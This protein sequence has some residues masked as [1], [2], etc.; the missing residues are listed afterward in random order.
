[1]T[2]VLPH[3]F[4][5]SHRAESLTHV[6]HVPP[7]AGSTAAWPSWAPP[8]LRTAFEARG[9]AL[10]WTHQAAAADL[11]WSGTHTVVATGT[12]SGKSLAYQL[13]ALSALLRDAKATMLYI[14][15]TKALAADQ[16]RSLQALDL[17]DTRPATF[18]GDT[19]REERDW[20]R[21]HARVV[22]TNPDMLHH[23]ILPNH[24]SWTRFLRGLRFVV[25]DECH[26][27]R[28][29]FGSHVAH[30]L[31]RL[32]RVTA[33]YTP[34]G[35]PSPCFVLA[36]A[37]SGDPQSSGSR[38]T[39][40]PMTAVTTDASPRG[41]VTFALWEPPLLPPPPDFSG[42]GEAELLLPDDPTLM[43]TVAER[44]TP[45]VATRPSATPHTSIPAPTT[46]GDSTTARGSTTAA[47]PTTTAGSTPAASP[48]T[49]AQS[50]TTALSLSTTADAK[51]AGDSANA[52]S[53]TTACASAPTRG[54]TTAA[55]P[56]AAHSS[57]TAGASAT[58]RRSTPTGGVATAAGGV[59]GAARDFA[60]AGRDAEPV[61]RSALRETADLLTEAV[62]AG[63]RTLAFVRSRKGA[64]VV[65]SMARRSLDQAVPGL[66]D[67]V[68]A[69]R[70]GYLREERRALE[71][72]L[73]D[74][75][76]LGLASTNAL[77]LGVDL[78][79][80]DAVLIS[81]YPGTL[82]SL[83]QQAG[84]AGRAGRDAL[85]VLVARDDPLDTYLVHHP[86]ALFGKPVEATVL[87]P[88][89]P[90]VLAPQLCC[91]AAELPLT[92]ADLPLFGPTAEATLDAL[93]ASGILRKRPSGWYWTERHRPDVDLRGAGGGP[94]AVVEEA[95]G[96]LL[97]T[98]DTGSA[99]HQVHTG[100]VHLHQGVSY[101]V[102]K[103]DLA[104]SVALVH[105]E[106]PDWSTH[107]RDVTSL[108]VLSV[109]Q[110]RT[111]GPVTLSLGEVEVTSQVVSYQRRRI[112]SGEVIDTCQLD[113]PE[114][115]LKTV[116]VWWTVSPEALDEAG[117]AEVDWPGA[118][119][120][121]EHASIGLLPL[122]ATCDRWDIGGLSTALHADT[123]LPTVFVY[124]GHPG[125]AGFAERAF[126]VATDW[127]GATRAVVAECRCEQGCPSCVQ[128]PKCGNGNNPLNKHDAVQVLSLVL[129]SL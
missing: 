17:P 8:S 2:A 115:I 42:I 49:S 128:S 31:R 44:T 11:A 62:I 21:Q 4:L 3:S 107:P 124:D 77:E 112:T 117:I 89:N 26:T 35:L 1:M 55:N 7:R 111:A 32:R 45:A 78:V 48:T 18:D 79:G 46:A 104:D 90:H 126:D 56:T 27:Y 122:V 93:V 71:R 64:E 108:T 73:M 84:R 43:T 85:C 25:V 127:L 114:R 100:A 86:E 61:R 103:L 92:P 59:A 94:I 9:V 40:L 39:G 60:G 82:A 19:S 15:P 123:G 38:L 101:V 37:T 99:H 75:T 47:T 63:V 50:P 70:A 109:R 80:L 95:T 125:G 129:A 36:S 88:G 110:T 54:S 119:H 67:R 12:G 97:G 23:G 28:G 58:A 81:G 121:A 76:L 96:R 16:L 6:E 53:S 51:T 29:V 83:W 34:R 41:G 87:D 22:L 52:H 91:A 105:A 120:A 57:T 20:V 113:L 118:L 33:R 68:A 30:V 106:E 5:P 116:A 24:A 10:P 72:D 14:S 13:P 98:V 69:Y 66:G 65:A 74:G 102:D